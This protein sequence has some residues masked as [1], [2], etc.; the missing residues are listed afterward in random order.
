MPAPRTVSSSP[1]RTCSNRSAP[2]ASISRTPPRTSASGPGFGKRPDCEGATLTTTRTPDSSSSSAET[3]SRSVWSMIATS[4]APSRRTSFLVRRSSFAAP[5]NST[6]AALLLTLHGG[7]EL[8]AAEHT[9]DLLAPLR[10][11]ERFDPR[12]SR[13]A[14]NL[15][16]AEMPPRAARDLGQVRDRDHLRALAQPLERLRNRVSRLAADAGVDLVEEHR[17]AAGDRR[18]RQRD[19]RQLAAGARSSCSAAAS[20]SILRSAASTALVAA[21][22]GSKPSS[23]ASSSACASA[24][25]A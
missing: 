2:G 19:P 17:L 6:K 9:L 23:S 25:R 12:V 11:A 1:S 18:D 5:V 15:L 4:S 24:D 13:I 3:R 16:D 22:T 7:Q 20:V 8:L 21:A 14:G 10:F